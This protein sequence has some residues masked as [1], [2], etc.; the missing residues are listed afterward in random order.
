[1]LCSKVNDIMKI[2]LCTSEGVFY[3]W[4]DGNDVKR[5]RYGGSDIVLPVSD[6]PDHYQNF[7]RVGAKSETR[8]YTEYYYS[9]LMPDLSG[10]GMKKLIKKSNHFC[11]GQMKNFLVALLTISAFKRSDQMKVALIGSKCGEGS[12]SWIPLF[13]RILMR[14]APLVILDCYDSAESN[15]TYNYVRGT[16]ELT[17][18]RF[19]SY[20]QGDGSEYDCV[21]DD[22][23]LPAIGLMEKEWNSPIWSR[24]IHDVTLYPNVFSMCFHP[25]EGR[26]FES[27]RSL[28]IRRWNTCGCSVCGV[29]ELVSFSLD[30]FKEAR[31]FG[32]MIERMSCEDFGEYHDM[33]LM[34]VVYHDLLVGKSFEP[35]QPAEERVLT[36]ISEMAPLSVSS[37]GL[38]RSSGAQ[39]SVKG[40]DTFNLPLVP[41]YDLDNSVF[42]QFSGKTVVFYGESPKILGSTPL[43]R[44]FKGPK[45]AKNAEIAFATNEENVSLA[46]GIPTLYVRPHVDVKGYVTDGSSFRGYLRYERKTVPVERV[47]EVF[48]N[49]KEHSSYEC[50]TSD[51]INEFFDLLPKAKSVIYRYI[52]VDKSMMLTIDKVHRIVGKRVQMYEFIISLFGG[53]E[54]QLEKRYVDQRVGHRSQEKN[55]EWREIPSV[56][57]DMVRK[58]FILNSGTTKKPTYLL[59]CELKEIT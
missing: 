41:S 38:Y 10:D 48:V 33:S 34:N 57:A 54:F 36:L 20:Y 21:V 3:Q 18:N 5:Y 24:K 27:G 8:R 44:V 6:V 46:F 1:M 49:Y 56:F 30:E 13:A 55:Q 53:K 25:L 29:F 22:A 4:V 42:P 59:N 47:P 9:G 16:S 14:Y 39:G 52:E 45:G 7:S 2:P 15:V 51:E 23:F 19:A 43:A 35:T 26:Q 40:R 28:N 37:K 58:N 12:G 11:G 50:N 31:A 17:I 32:H